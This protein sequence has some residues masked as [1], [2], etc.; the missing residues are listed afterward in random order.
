MSVD[1]S[2]YRSRTSQRLRAEG[3]DEGRVEGRVED[4]IEKTLRLLEARGIDVPGPARKRIQ[5][6][7][8]L[9]VLDRW[10]DRAITATDIAEV[11]AE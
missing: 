3:R 11:F 9:E 8:D 7:L 1:L 6:C 10:F 2:F 5:S 4:V